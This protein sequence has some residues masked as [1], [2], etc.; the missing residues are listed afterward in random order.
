MARINFSLQGHL[1]VPFA[2]PKWDIKKIRMTGVSTTATYFE[3]ETPCVYIDKSKGS[4]LRLRHLGDAWP[5]DGFP[6]I[7]EWDKA[8][9]W[10]RDF[11]S[12]NGALDTDSERAFLQVYFDYIEGITRERLPGGDWH[13]H[14]PIRNDDPNYVFEALLPLP[15]AHLYVVNPLT[16]YSY[17]DRSPDNMFKVDFAFWTGERLVA[18]EIDGGSH[19]GSDRHVTKDRMLQRA[20]VQVI[21]ILNSEI[22][23]HGTRV[24]SKLL[25][26]SF[27]RLLDS[28]TPHS[29]NPLDG[30]PF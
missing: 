24:V 13:P 30:L 17:I 1:I 10:V 16:D 29:S 19:I 4:A 14:D 12:D 3:S 27:G 20:G 8:L 18:V 9:W 26:R 5:S 15:Q 11:I 7:E 6:E 2:C 25:P 21:H 22:I 23:Q 28:G